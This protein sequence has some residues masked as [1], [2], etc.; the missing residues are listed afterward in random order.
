MKR[1]F[2]LLANL[3]FYPI[4][5]IVNSVKYRK[6]SVPLCIAFIENALFVW[7]NAKYMYRLW[8]IILYR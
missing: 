3:W 4:I 2:A 7:R 6:F 8:R 5:G 1:T